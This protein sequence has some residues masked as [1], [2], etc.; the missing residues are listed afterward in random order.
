MMLVGY[1]VFGCT[2]CLLCCVCVLGGL[3]W[4]VLLVLRVYLWFMGVTG[5]VG[6]DRLVSVDGL[7]WLLYD[8]CGFWLLFVIVLGVSGV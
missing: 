6:C 3:V 4:I 8:A 2:G 1:C 5:C 7:I